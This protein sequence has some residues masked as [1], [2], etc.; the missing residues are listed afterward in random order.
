[1]TFNEKLLRLNYK[2]ERAIL[3]QMLLFLLPLV[4]AGL[5][6]YFYRLPSAFVLGVF[7]FLLIIGYRQ[8][9]NNKFSKLEIR[10]EEEFIG[11]I[12]NLR[13]YLSN[14]VNVYSAFQSLRAYL[15]PWFKSKVEVLLTRIDEDKTIAPYIELA[16]NFSNPLVEE[17]MIAIYQLNESGNG[18]SELWQFNYLFLRYQTNLIFNKNQKTLRYFEKT[19]LLPLLASGLLVIGIAIGIMGVI[20]EVI[21][22]I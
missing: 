2:K 12:N 10:Q 7:G 3:I 9:I 13:V 22:G 6:F 5:I 11:A 1:M 21:N 18:I 19:A 20:G 17:M 8:I 16:N 14:G 4:G 15:K